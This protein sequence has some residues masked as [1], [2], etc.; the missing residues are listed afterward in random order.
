ME[1]LTTVQRLE[2]EIRTHS[3][4][5]KKAIKTGKLPLKALTRTQSDS[6][7][8]IS[9]THISLENRAKER[10][11]IEYREKIKEGKY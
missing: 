10:K 1:F 4:S 2:K 7:L 8:H 9:S 11:I 3:P 5:L 6:N